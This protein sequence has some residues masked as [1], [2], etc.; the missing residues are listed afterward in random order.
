[1][2]SAQGTLVYFAALS[3]S[4]VR[5]EAAEAAWRVGV[6][7]SRESRVFW[8]FGDGES[9]HIAVFDPLATSWS[10]ALWTTSL[11]FPISPGV[12][13]KTV[14]GLDSI[15]SACEFAEFGASGESVRLESQCVWRASASGELGSCA[16]SVGSEP[17]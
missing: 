5:A 1:V 7:R 3:W 10:M 13:D 11:S 6:A 9:A 2:Q 12:M 17:V 8:A 4:G 15:P 16:A 14:A